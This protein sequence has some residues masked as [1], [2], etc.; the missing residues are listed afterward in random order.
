MA[1]RMRSLAKRSGSKMSISK[2]SMNHIGT[3]PFKYKVDVFI[4]Y[5]DVVKTTGDVCVTWERRG[6]TNATTCVKVKDNKAVFRETLSMETTLFRKNS[7]TQKSGATSTEGQELKFDEKIAKFALRKGG[8]EGKAIGKMH[9]NL[10]DHI[11]GPNGT[12]FADLKL[13]NG[14]IIVT[15]IESTL[16]HMGKKSK[17]NGSGGGS[18]A[19]SE[20]TDLD[21]GVEDDSI[22]GDDA[23]DLGDL[24]LMIAESGA[25]SGAEPG[26]PLSS[27]RGAA[28]PTKTGSE[29]LGMSSPSVL[30]LKVA[31]APTPRATQKD[32]APSPPAPTP[33]NGEETPKPTSKERVKCDASLTESPSLRDKVKAKLKKDKTSARKE[34]SI[35]DEVKAPAAKQEL[36]AKVSTEVSQLREAVT[37]LTADNKKL[38]T[39]KQA[40]MEEIE[41]LRSELAASEK[42]LEEQGGD[43]PSSPRGGTAEDQLRKEKKELTAKV[44]ELEGQIEGL[45]EELDNAPPRNETLPKEK[46]KRFD[47]SDYK[48]QI[49]D[50]ELALR[51]EPQYLDV[52][53]ELKVT[54]MAL[55]LANMEKEQ[56]LFALKKFEGA[57]KLAPLSPVSQS[58]DSTTGAGN[59]WGLG[60]FG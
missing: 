31:T 5:V 28:A 38:R 27:P 26:K 22:F 13:S 30:K 20:T 19:N 1:E 29:G 8:G 42:A 40:M 4:S 2:G 45:L 35:E 16:L 12:V 32:S 60:L 3:T 47:D 18:E 14:S 44:K 7:P 52:V 10:A 46:S 37:A 59:G 6:K 17:K 56:A 25:D 24:D 49:V 23:E 41:E 21:G 9:V 34:R 50:L 58:G 15:K 39:S 43:C 51:R 36:S 55:A 54:K 53:D 11:K 57:A 48:R 33:A